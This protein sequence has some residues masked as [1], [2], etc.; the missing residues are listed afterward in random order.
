MPVIRNPQ[1]TLTREGSNLKINVTYSADFNTFERRL[2][3]LGL[4]YRQRLAVIGVDPPGATTGAVLAVSS[5]F[6]NPIF[7]DVTDGVG[8][9]TVAGGG[10]LGGGTIIVSRAELDEDSNPQVPPDADPDEIRCRIRIEAFGLP[11]AVTPDAFTD[12]EVLGGVFQPAA[13]AQA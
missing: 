5:R 3:G 13:A 10:P 2:V 9:Q 8:K 1:L 6:P 12:Q 4:K 7:L 11:P